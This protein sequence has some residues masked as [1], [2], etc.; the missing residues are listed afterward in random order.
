[1]GHVETQTV[2][3]RYTT[4]H[5]DADFRQSQ[6]KEIKGVIFKIISFDVK[7]PS[8]QTS[9]QYLLTFKVRLSLGPLAIVIVKY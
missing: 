5:K 1:M 8:T 2:D 4:F 6:M 9:G 3:G 7:A